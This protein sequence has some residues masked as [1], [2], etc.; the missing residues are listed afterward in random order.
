[1]TCGETAPDDWRIFEHNTMEML[2]LMLRMFRKYHRFAP[3]V[4]YYVT[5]MARTLHNDHETLT[6]TLAPLGLT[7]AYDG[8]TIEI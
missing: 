5:H 2:T 8:L 3:D 4:K 1:M 7:P 6:N